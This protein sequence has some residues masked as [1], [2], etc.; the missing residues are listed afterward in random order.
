MSNRSYVI[1]VVG[2]SSTQMSGWLPILTFLQRYSVL[3]L[4]LMTMIMIA[5]LGSATR[6]LHTL[7]SA[8]CV[9]FTGWHSPDGAWADSTPG[10]LHTHRSFCLWTPGALGP[11]RR[12]SCK[13]S[14]LLRLC[15]AYYQPD[16]RM[17]SAEDSTSSSGRTSVRQL[18][19][20][21]AYGTSEFWPTASIRDTCNELQSFL[22]RVL[23][24]INGSSYQ[25]G[26]SQKESPGWHLHGRDRHNSVLL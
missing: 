22:Y 20:S 23:M 17:A 10:L 15:A 26:M 5:V 24:Q 11:S 2:R 18:D 13:E 16:D 14:Q 21:R 3:L 9:R 4:G 8:G 19:C 25:A 7:L 6:D 1:P 12:G